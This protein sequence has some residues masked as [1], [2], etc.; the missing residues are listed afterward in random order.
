ML[1]RMEKLIALYKVLSGSNPQWCHTVLGVIRNAAEAKLCNNASVLA[2]MEHN[3]TN[4]E[5]KFFFLL[6][7]AISL[8]P[9]EMRQRLKKIFKDF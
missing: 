7:E 3:T 5:R 8:I 2:E 9:N 6:C 4:D 1:R